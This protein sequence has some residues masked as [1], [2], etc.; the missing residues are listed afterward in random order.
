M[1]QFMRQ[2]R[3]VQATAREGMRNKAVSEGSLSVTS[4]PSPF[5][6]INGVAYPRNGFFSVDCL[7]VYLFCSYLL[8][9]PNVKTEVLEICARLDQLDRQDRRH[10]PSQIVSR[11]SREDSQ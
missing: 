1:S 9:S 8:P 5:D 4:S 2:T 7:I 11:A 6:V 10:S 3:S